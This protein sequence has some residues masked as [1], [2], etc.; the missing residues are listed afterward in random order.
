MTS[1]STNTLKMSASI[2]DWI[3]NVN[4]A[5]LMKQL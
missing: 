5:K 2:T 3:P 4:W 1:F